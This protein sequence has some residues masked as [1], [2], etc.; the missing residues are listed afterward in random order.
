MTGLRFTTFLP[1]I[2]CATFCLSGPVRADTAHALEEVP[3]A[4][5]ADQ[6]SG[7]V[8]FETVPRQPEPGQRFD[9]AMRLGGLWMGEHFSGQDLVG[10]DGFDVVSGPPAAP[11]ALRAGRPRANLSVAF[12]RGFGSNALFALGPDGFPKH[13]ARGEGAVAVLFDTDQDAIGLR[14]HSDYP[15]PLGQRPTSRGHV[16]LI[17]YT[18][19]G[20]VIARHHAQLSLGITE[21]AL[22]RTG[23]QPDIAGMLI[24]NDDP[25]GIAIDDILY[26]IAA[27]LG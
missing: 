24:T 13:S 23:G 6:S 9:H 20:E 5:P 8:T 25:G 21:I 17:L 7:R 2:L 11:L 16:Y 22:R 14:I 12:H 3:Y 10:Q 27:M 1:L 15:D 19:T 26:Q 18:R 4:R